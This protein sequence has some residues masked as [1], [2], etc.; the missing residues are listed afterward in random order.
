[1]LW[2]EK[3]LIQISFLVVGYI[4]KHVI[5]IRMVNAPDAKIWINLPNGVLFVIAVSRMATPIALN[6]E[7]LS[8]MEDVKNLKV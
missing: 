8:K 5:N 1:M 7:I 2:A 6:A 3:L 4:A